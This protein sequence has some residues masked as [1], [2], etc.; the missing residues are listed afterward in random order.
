MNGASRW[1]EACAAPARASTAA[2]TSGATGNGGRGRDRM[3]WL[4]EFVM[5]AAVRRALPNTRGAGAAD[6]LQAL[7]T[8]DAEA[9]I[10]AAPGLVGAGAQAPAGPGSA[11]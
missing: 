9:C 8:L 6:A 2:A 5:G 11:A 10:Q 1:L 7:S 4:L 3:S